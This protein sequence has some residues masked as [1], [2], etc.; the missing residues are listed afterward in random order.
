MNVKLEIKAKH[1]RADKSKEKALIFK[2]ENVTGPGEARHLVRYLTMELLEDYPE[3]SSLDDL[4]RLSWT[5][6][7]Q[8][9]IMLKQYPQFNL[10][11][12]YILT[13]DEI[14]D[15]LCVLK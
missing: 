15:D 12:D 3:L 10:N 9:K 4:R 11:H 6:E 13:V 14:A 8:D 1:G 2:L 5:I 7:R